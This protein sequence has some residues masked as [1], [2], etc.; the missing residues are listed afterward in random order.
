MMCL[1]GV[2]LADI[3]AVS[4]YFMGGEETVGALKTFQ[5][6]I[7]NGIP[8]PRSEKVILYPAPQQI[9]GMQR[10]VTASGIL[11][12]MEQAGFVLA[13]VYPEKHRG[14]GFGYVVRLEF[15]RP[16]QQERD[17][18]RW[19]QLAEPQLEELGGILLSTTFCLSHC[20]RYDA[21]VP[22]VKIILIGSIEQK[23]Q[24]RIAFQE[25]NLLL[26]I[27]EGSKIGPEEQA[28]LDEFLGTVVRT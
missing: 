10:R 28:E 18:N 17:E 9:W 27:D 8:V 4:V 24:R 23:P 22:N 15:A 11:R 14:M 21:P 12:E 6:A 3:G 26:M 7:V 16:E 19:V 20:R 2:S 1:N 25:G 5:Y 13:H